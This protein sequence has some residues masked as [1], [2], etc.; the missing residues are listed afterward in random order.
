M[1]DKPTGDWQVFDNQIQKLL[2]FFYR[3]SDVKGKIVL[4]H[5]QSS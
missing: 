5:S 3:E 4:D 1:E 2:A